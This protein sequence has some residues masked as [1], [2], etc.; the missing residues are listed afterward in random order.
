M[1]PAAMALAGLV[2]L[3]AAG[4]AAAAPLDALWTDWRARFVAGDGRVVDDGNGGI[5]HSEGQGYGMLLAGRAGDR[6]TFD[7]LWTFTRAVLGVRGDG[8][9]AWRYDP[10]AANR[11]SDPNDA[12]DGDLLIA[13]ALAE[14]GR[15][16]PEGGY[17]EDAAVV[18]RAVQR[19]AVTD[20][21]GVRL[22]LPGAAGFG[23]GDR[24]DGPVVNPSYW[25]Y[26][27]FPALAAVAPEYD[28]EKLSA[29][30]RTLLA[31]GGFGPSRLPP[32]WL[33]LGGGA[34]A[35]AKGF[36]AMFGWNALR[37]PLYLAWAGAGAAALAPY[38]ALW[39]AGGDA[40]PSLLPLPEGPPRSFGEAGY[41][42]V[43]ALVACAVGGAPLPAALTRPVAGE[44]YYPATLRLLAVA[45][46]T[47]RYPACL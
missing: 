45:A 1:R 14:A 29:G 4:S 16:W 13:W 42:A 47:E 46:A 35:P 2:A 21:G 8:L 37:V 31:A 10:R 9:F 27:A 34:P 18:A 20:H 11:V 19:M 23:A 17:T 43:P 41:R 30:G 32:D 3:A 15:R 22:L 28:W 33:A 12:S 38:A 7:R 25:V 24:P 5:S 40:D 44:H 6:A 26:P 36:P 39:P